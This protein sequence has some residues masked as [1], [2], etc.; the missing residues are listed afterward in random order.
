MPKFDLKNWMSELFKINLTDLITSIGSGYGRRILDSPGG[1]YDKIAELPFF[2]KLKEQSKPTKFL[3]EAANN[4]FAAFLD[5]K[6]GDA[7]PLRKLLKEVF[8]DT[9]SEL[10]KRLINGG[11]SPKKIL[12]ENLDKISD[13][14]EENLLAILLMFPEEKLQPLVKELL[15][16]TDSADRTAI[17][18]KLR[19]LSAEESLKLAGFQE[20]TRKVIFELLQG[21]KKEKGPSLPSVV[22]RD[23]ENGLNF[24]SDEIS[25]RRMMK[26]KEGSNDNG[27]T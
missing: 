20:E 13:P 14:T 18:Q 22:K 15:A 17:I 9:S 25:R 5:Q 7:S 27:N 8:E 16:I 19:G 11:E 24:F 4:I 6:I 10:N 23:I 12:G 3:I 1:L 2:Q 26:K 21:S